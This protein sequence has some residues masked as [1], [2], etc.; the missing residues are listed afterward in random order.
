M[1]IKKIDI[2][3]YGPIKE[4][5]FAPAQFTCIF[6]MNESGKTA[7]VEILSYILFKKTVAAL[8]F[9]KPEHAS[10]DVEENGKISRLPAKK[11]HLSL[12]P[13]D[14]A[15]L[16]YVQASESAL[17]KE[18]EE[19]N[20]WE[21]MKTLFSKFGEGVSFAKLDEKIFKTVG[22]TQKREEWTEEKEEKIDSERERFHKLEAYIKHI[23][24]VEA[25]ENELLQVN[26]KYHSLQEEAERIENYERYQ[27]Y[28]ELTSLHHEYQ[29]KKVHLQDYERYKDEYL[30]TWR[31]L[32][33]ERNVRNKSEHELNALNKTIP[34]LEEQ[35]LEL[36]Q[37]EQMI[38]K[39]DLKSCI[40]RAHAAAKQPNLLIPCI[41]LAVA[42][43]IFALSFIVST[44]P[45]AAATFVFAASLM[46]FA[47][48]LYKRQLFTKTVTRDENLLM[49]AKKV[50]PDIKTLDEVADMIDETKEQKAAQQALL[51]EKKNRRDE[52]MQGRTVAAID[53]EISEL[54]KKTGLAELSDLEGKLN[55]KMA[56]VR[57]KDELYAKIFGILAERDDKKWQRMID[58][59]KTPKPDIEPD[60]NRKKDVEHELKITRHKIEDLTSDINIHRRTLKG[61]YRL[62]D[63][64]AAFI[65]H[66]RLEKKLHDYDL[67][68]RA[69][70]TARKILKEMS[71][72]LDEYINDIMK[73]N[74]S[75]SEYFR[76]V[77]GRY[78]EVEVKRK[79][80]V[81]TQKDGQRF[82]TDELSSGAQD[83]LLFC[84]RIAALK[85]IYPEGSFLILDDAF[86]FADWARRPKLAELLKKFVDEGNQVIYLTSDDH[87]RDLLEK[88]GAGV[89]IL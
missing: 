51:K 88:Y 33:A 48:T 87:T 15:N 10:I 7:L 65:E 29:G 63:D 81:I 43:L 19:R 75:L 72:E 58:E 54:R 68:K 41:T 79:K 59:K 69:A 39:E 25:K 31:G 76:L 30:N 89:I 24:E 45:R 23:N 13:A 83:Q 4:F 46:Y 5:I 18:R 27:K 36:E 17:Y 6:G 21:G 50:F 86:I 16:L 67:E 12:P 32:E 28:T 49:K 1:K 35:V 11:P 56:V 20:F 9:S 84:F 85:K 80:F 60:M 26:E 14:I 55:E 42:V 57:K 37:R 38:T 2:R 62:P 71:S 61:E 78:E 82:S 52:F 47:F 77:T 70:L 74:E 53:K 8:R 73:G 40:V 64:R 44:I 22:L 66:A 3:G 34:A